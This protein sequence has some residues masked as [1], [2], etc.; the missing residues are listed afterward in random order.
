MK[1]LSSL[2]QEI[3]TEIEITTLDVLINETTLWLD[4]AM[5]KQEKQSLSETPAVTVAQI[6][7]KTSKLDREVKYLINKLKFAPPPT[8]PTTTQG[9]V[10]KKPKKSKKAKKAS[11]KNETEDGREAE[12]L[13]L[14][15]SP[16]E[17]EQET[18]KEKEQESHFK[19][20]VGSKE[21]EAEPTPTP[22][23][24]SESSDP[25]HTEL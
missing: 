19:E 2:G 12:P 16:I 23:K 24:S 13:E 6:V 15:G 9:D 4:D 21:R 11:E 22:S 1:N 5:E 25:P 10:N 20:E 8:I 14:E 7:E 17:G 3:F 18:K